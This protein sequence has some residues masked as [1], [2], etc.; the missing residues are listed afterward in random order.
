MQEFSKIFV[1]R[2]KFTS[3]QLRHDFENCNSDLTLISSSSILWSDSK[4]LGSNGSPVIRIGP[5]GI[6]RVVNLN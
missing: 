1:L 2:T 5:F 4:L 6:K 3:R